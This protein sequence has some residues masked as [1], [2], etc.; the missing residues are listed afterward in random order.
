MFSQQLFE[1][2]DTFAAVLASREPVMQQ[3][4]RVIPVGDS[5]DN[6]IFG[7]GFTRTDVH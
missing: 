4:Q 6:L 2:G 5:A 3:F 7:D 1:S